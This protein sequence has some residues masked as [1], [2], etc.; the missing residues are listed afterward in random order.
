MPPKCTYPG[1]TGI[2]QEGNLEKSSKANCKLHLHHAC[3]ADPEHQDNVEL[4]LHKFCYSCYNE[5][6]KQANLKMKNSNTDNDDAQG[7]TSP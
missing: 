3:Q 6:V 7:N 5:E 2:F 4:D 1:C